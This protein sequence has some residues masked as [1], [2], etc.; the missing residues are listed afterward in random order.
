MSEMTKEEMDLLVDIFLHLFKGQDNDGID[1]MWWPHID[2]ELH[3]ALI[4]T[5]KVN[6]VEKDGKVFYGLKP[7]AAEE[8]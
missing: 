4:A 2:D 8:L 3:T 5:G 1:M 7:K 6:S